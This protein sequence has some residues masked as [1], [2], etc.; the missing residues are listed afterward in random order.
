MTG[1]LI[2]GIVSIIVFIALAAYNKGRS[3][4]D[5]SGK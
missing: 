3:V 1:T 4:F 5:R 2:F